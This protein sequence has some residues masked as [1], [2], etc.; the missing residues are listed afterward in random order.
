[1]TLDEDLYHATTIEERIGWIGLPVTSRRILTI[2]L[3]RLED[4]RRGCVV[5][6]GAWLRR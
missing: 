1:M 2:S 4:G 6:P 5:R 3:R